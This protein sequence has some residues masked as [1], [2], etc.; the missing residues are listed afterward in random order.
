MSIK[1]LLV[2][3]HKMFR[4]G[5]RN[6]I[7]Q[8]MGLEPIGEAKDGN[9]AVAMAEKYSP[10]VMIMDLSMPGLNGLEATRKILEIRPQT[11]IIILSMHSD[12]RYVLESLKVGAKG[13]VL[14]DVDF[15]ELVQAIHAAV[16]DRIYLSQKISDLVIKDFVKSA[17]SEDPS[18]Y[19]LLS[20]RER[21]VLQHL[22]EGKGTKVIANHLN[23]SVKTIET[24]RKNLMDKLDLHSVAALT[25][26]A[27]REGITP[28]E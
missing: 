1:I 4:D 12:R 9:E 28:L 26:Y 15:T 14:K 18:A 13:Y 7:S 2:D 5:L 8:E 20:A 16:N 3:D 25:K 19:S 22:A 11:K 27:I 23:V 24:Y 17:K 6:L 10:D 21:E